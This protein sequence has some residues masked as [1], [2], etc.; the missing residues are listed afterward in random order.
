M[1]IQYDSTEL[2][3]ATYV[4]RYV[5]HET[6][7]ERLIN[8]IK[9][10]RQNGEIIIDDTM[11]V[12]FID[13]IGVLI[14]TSQSDL[15]TKIDAFKELIAR[16]DKNLDITWAGGTRRYVCRSLSHRF[17]RDF[18][19]ILHVPY[20]IRFFVP[21]G[22][23]KNTSETTA[24]DKSG[25]TA[26]TDTE[27]IT[28]EGSYAPKARHKITITTRGNADVIRV[29]NVTSGDYMDVDLD[30]FSNGD[31]FEIDEE[32]QTIKKNG[33]TN[34]NYRGKFPVVS[35]GA[36][37]LKITVY[38]S[39]SNGEEYQVSGSSDSVLGSI[40]TDPWMAQSFVATQS[41]RRQKVAIVLK[42]ITSGALGGYGVLKI[43]EDNNGNPENGPALPIGTS[44]EFRLNVSSMPTNFTLSDFTWTG[45]DSTKPFLEKGKRY[46]LVFNPTNLTG[47]DANNL[48]DWRHNSDPTSYVNGKS[49]WRKSDILPWQDGYAESDIS[50][51]GAVAQVDADFEIYRGSD[52]GAASH[53]IV[54]QIYY[55]KKYL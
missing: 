14:G 21:T 10:A 39:G 41:G 22:Y 50:D 30:G 15:E 1:S 18:Y 45:A 43:Y 51:G 26:T 17:E 52:G 24:L 40:S 3:N 4:P 36:N 46:W 5:K 34:L 32:N 2:Q 13:I 27:A 47:T 31:Y 44:N 12:K 6:A 11:A 16:K 23:G 48:V 19:N 42:K 38:G 33:T 37:S 49:M 8:S 53:S 55:T 54:W 7:P 25:I 35:T 29:E 28:F 20:S 9:L